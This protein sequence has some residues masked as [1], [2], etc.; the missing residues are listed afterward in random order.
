MTILDC[1][2]SSPVWC[3][4]RVPNSYQ[5]YP[6]LS[7]LASQY[8]LSVNITAA[9]LATNGVQDGW[10]D[11]VLTGQHYQ[12][13]AGIRYL[14]ELKIDIRQIGPQAWWKALSSR[15]EFLSANNTLALDP[16]SLSTGCL[17]FGQSVFEQS[18]GQTLGIEVCIPRL[19]RSRPWLSDLILRHGVAVSITA[20]W[21]PAEGADAG[22]FD[23]VVSGREA[24]VVAGV[25]E[26]QPYGVNLS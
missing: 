9:C 6:V 1:G 24:Q 23:L 22:R 25:A 8:H 15:L 20:A 17:S 14:H 19:Y 7:R 16:K 3:R 10:F 5:P 21:L 26:L 4:I 11:P 2:E 13:L 12:V 18:C